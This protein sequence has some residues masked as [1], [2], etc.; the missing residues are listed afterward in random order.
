MGKSAVGPGIKAGGPNYVV[1]LMEFHNRE[2]TDRREDTDPSPGYDQWAFD[3]FHTWH[4]HFLLLGEDNF[5]RYRPIERLRVRVTTDDTPWDI[6]TRV[7]AA[8][9][10]GCTTTVSVPP[11]LTGP[12]TPSIANLERLSQDTDAQIE[13]IAETDAELAAIIRAGQTDRVRYAAADRVPLIVRQ[14]AAEALQ[15]IADAP[16]L[17]HGRVELLWYF[18]EQSFTH[19]YHRYGNLGIRSG[20]A[21]TEPV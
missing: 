19:L 20:E 2:P 4:D 3:E 16:P 13:F 1:P 21:R 11:N 5:R 6:A 10:A 7:A 8:H 17:A 14:A 12:A 9:A 18:Q 15:S